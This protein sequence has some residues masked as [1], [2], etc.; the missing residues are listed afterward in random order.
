MLL[1]Y[2]FVGF[3]NNNLNSGDP[4]AILMECISFT[5]LVKNV[6]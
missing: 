2:L 4:I 6:R 3:C 5:V 1:W